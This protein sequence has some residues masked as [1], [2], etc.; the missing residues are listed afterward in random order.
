M[1]EPFVVAVTVAKPPNAA[2]APL[3]GAVNVTVTPDNGF[4]NASVSFA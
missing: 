2:L 4:E 1:P 3:A